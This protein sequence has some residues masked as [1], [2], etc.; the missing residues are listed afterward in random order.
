MTF[1]TSTIFS[2][3]WIKTLFL[4]AAVFMSQTAYGVEMTLVQTHPGDIS[5]QKAGPMSK[6]DTALNRVFSEHRAHIR[7]KATTPF[8]PSNPFLQCARGKIVIDAI[9]SEDGNALLDDLKG[10]GLKKE[11]R[12]GSIVSGWLPVAAIDKTVA[13]KSLRFI[14][15]SFR[16][17]TNVGD[18][19][20]QG[21]EAMRAYIARSENSVNG[22]GI[23][24]GVLSDSYDQQGGASSDVTTNDLPS[25]VNVLDD[26]ANCGILFV[27]PC[28]D[29]GRAMMQIVHDV[30]PGADLAFHTA[31]NGMANFANGIRELYADGADVIVDDVM[32]FNEPMFQDGIIAQAVDE[33]VAGGV[34]YFSAA[35]NQARDSYEHDYVSSGEPLYVYSW[36]FPER[37]V[38]ILHDF[39]PGE[40]VDWL[41]NITVPLDSCAIIT[42][43]WDEP[44]GSLPG[45]N[46][47]EHD[48]DI[49][50]VDEGGM[51]ILEK[52]DADNVLSGE[53]VEVLQFCNSYASSD[54][55]LMIS[56]FS[57]TEPPDSWTPPEVLMKYVYFGNMTVNE[58]ATDS[59]T[60]YGHANAAGAE[61]IG[62][63]YYEETPEFYEGPPLLEYFSS[64]GGTPI[65]F[66]TGGV[67]LPEPEVRNKPGIVAPDGVN[68]TFFY[69]TIDRNGDG[70]PDFSGTSAAAPH[71]A[72]VAGLMLEANSWATPGEIYEA[73]ESTAFDMGDLG[74]DYDSGY[75]LVQADLAVSAILSGNTPPT[76]D[77][78]YFTNELTVRFTDESED[79]DGTIESWDWSFGDGNLSSEQYPVHTYAASGT[80]T[81]TLKVTDDDGGTD[82]TSQGVTVSDPDQINAPAN[83]VAS[84]V[85][86][87][88]VILSWTDTSDN[89]IG[90]KVERAIKT[91][92][93]YDFGVID[94]VGANV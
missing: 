72:A 54:F 74:F 16:P 53:P 27:E 84:V 64:A 42:L 31:F 11:A 23:K 18:V 90:F 26:S 85:G 30:A 61:A 36:P 10:L 92:G 40:G 76:A 58:Y 48:I 17:I 21:D 20:S 33:V 49:Y 41:Q 35:G 46:G 8:R 75:G 60:V 69:P 62:A 47:A 68:T 83:L 51:T 39:D 1:P 43:Q 9:A 91:R 78:S 50:L 82:T 81:V 57:E 67:R 65:W 3:P 52:S 88:T 13:L 7:G 24:V 56:F 5:I 25:D 93:K 34:A 2:S 70:T 77:F 79:P 80:Y 55:H 63:A 28:T 59:G 14:S 45:G 4:A 71:A 73:L 44:F 94:E 37:F 19:T 86:G 32:Y 6:A 66:G 29:E 89:E 38:G 12:F 87:N 15:A 22:T